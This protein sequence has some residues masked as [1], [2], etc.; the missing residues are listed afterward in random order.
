[1]TSQP[2]TRPS[3]LTTSA[4]VA[5]TT[6]AAGTLTMLLVSAR[7]SPAILIFLYTGWVLLPYVAL[8]FG[9][10]RMTL[11]S[12]EAA[13]VMHVASLLVVGVVLTAYVLAAMLPQAPRP[14]AVFLLVPLACHLVT[15]GAYAI[16]SARARAAT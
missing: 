1:M 10:R 3:L 15:A 7:N 12:A 8:A 16:A 4:T 6:G 13:T 11:R 2:M 9:R 5:L 14:A